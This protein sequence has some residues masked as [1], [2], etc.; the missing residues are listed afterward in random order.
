M[1]KAK[2]LGNNEADNA[3]GIL[4]NAIITVPLKY[5]SNFWRSREMPLVNC[6]VE[7]KFKWRKYCLL[8]AAGTD[9]NIDFTI[10]DTKLYVPAVTLSA[11]DNQKLP[12]L[13]SKGFE[14]S[15]YLNKYKTKSENKNTTNEY[16]YFLESNFVG[17]NRLFVLVCSNQ[18]ADSKIFNP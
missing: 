16:R 3:D 1:Y 17:V 2:L 5:L 8:S 14:R 4:K 9:N 18:D 10:K 12:N 6:K 11:R 15:V 7:L 13:L